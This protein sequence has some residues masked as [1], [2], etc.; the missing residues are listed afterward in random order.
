[1]VQI[2]VLALLHFY[3]RWGQQR[4]AVLATPSPPWSGISIN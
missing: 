3:T 4:R 1:M 2:V